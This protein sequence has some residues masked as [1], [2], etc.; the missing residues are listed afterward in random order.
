[1]LAVQGYQP[2]KEYILEHYKENPESFDKLGI[3]FEYRKKPEH[4]YNTLLPPDAK[5]RDPKPI[6]TIIA[7]DTSQSFAIRR[8]VAS[9]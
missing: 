2:K 3:A 9:E 1:M 6:V 5:S 7:Q 4:T 8:G